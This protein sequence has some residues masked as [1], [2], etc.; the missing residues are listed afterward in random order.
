MS[1]EKKLISG[2]Y[3]FLEHTEGYSITHN[4]CTVV[5]INYYNFFFNNSKNKMAHVLVKN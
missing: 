5:Y 3:L 1:K 4:V 2:W